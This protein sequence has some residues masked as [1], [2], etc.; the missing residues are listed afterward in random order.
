MNH[1]HYFNDETLYQAFCQK[2]KSVHGSTSK[3]MNE[4]MQLWLAKHQGWSSVFHELAPQDDDFRFEQSR[5]HMHFQR[6]DVF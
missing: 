6:K 3:A 5:D 2:G 1:T 4:A